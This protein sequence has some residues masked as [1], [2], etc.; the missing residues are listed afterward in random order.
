[1]SAV[2]VR[3]VGAAGLGGAVSTAVI[4]ALGEFAD[5]ELGEEVAAAPACR[6]SSH[7]GRYVSGVSA[8]RTRKD[9]FRSSAGSSGS[10]MYSVSPS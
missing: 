2:P 8:P 5:I 3:K 1:M 7:C 10:A 4:W 9:R 6:S